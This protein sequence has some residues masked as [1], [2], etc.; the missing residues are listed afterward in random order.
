MMIISSLFRCSRVHLKT[1]PTSGYID[2]TKSS[3]L[4]PRTMQARNCATHFSTI[5]DLNAK[6]IKFQEKIDL[7]EWR[8]GNPMTLDRKIEYVVNIIKQN[9]DVSFADLFHRKLSNIEDL[10]KRNIPSA[11]CALK[12]HIAFSQRFEEE[13]HLFMEMAIYLAGKGFQIP[14]ELEQFREV[15]QAA[16]K[17]QLVIDPQCLEGNIFLTVDQRPITPGESQGSAEWYSDS[18][19]EK[20]ENIDT[21]TIYVASN[22]ILTQFS[23]ETFPSENIDPQGRLSQKETISHLPYTLLCINPRRSAHPVGFNSDKASIEKTFVKITFS[24]HI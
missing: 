10:K 19:S 8:L 21:D 15:I 20:S 18:Y 1:S 2:S 9:P 3:K 6:K 24:K 11:V 23:K 12:E 4:F 22:C 5:E 14:K 17:H 7:K 13:G 16:V